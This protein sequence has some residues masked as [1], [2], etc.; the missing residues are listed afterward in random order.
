MPVSVA[1]CQIY[2]VRNSGLVRKRGTYDINV[3]AVVGYRYQ[4]AIV[5]EVDTIYGMTAVA[6]LL[7]QC[8][9]DVWR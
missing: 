4:L 2:F 7:A 1:H 3:W 9:V 5:R 8:F 6:R